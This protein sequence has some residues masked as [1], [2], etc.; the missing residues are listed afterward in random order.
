V[1]GRIAVLA[2]WLAVALVRD[3]P[4]MD[5]W[6]RAYMLVALPALG[7]IYLIASKRG[8]RDG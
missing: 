8:G 7:L 5:G 1:T 6:R 3:W 4:A 2:V